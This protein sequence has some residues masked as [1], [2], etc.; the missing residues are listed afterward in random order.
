MFRWIRRSVVSAIVATTLHAAPKLEEIPTYQLG[1]DA[2]GGRLWEV[3]ASRFEAALQTEDLTPELRAAIL[4]RLTESRIR[5]NQAELALET[6]NDPDLADHPDRPFWQAQAIAADGRFLDAI[7]AFKT[8]EGDDRH[9]I[10]IALTQALLERA[11]GDPRAALATLDAILAKPKPPATARL[12]KADILLG[13][14]PKR[15]P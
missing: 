9:R 6:L 2:L 3:A 7:E 8:I 4:L 12:L 10:E 14:P 13:E 1:L 11:I 5:G 15:H